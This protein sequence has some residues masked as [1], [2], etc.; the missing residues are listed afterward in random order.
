MAFT[1]NGLL[2]NAPSVVPDASFFTT[3]LGFTSNGLLGG[4]GEENGSGQVP[5]IQGTLEEREEDEM[6]V[7]EGFSS[8]G[9]LGGHSSSC[10]S[11]AFY[12]C[13]LKSIGVFSF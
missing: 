6:M 3:D 5:A 9:L 7:D 10:S 1:S 13:W 8:N 2:G 12:M 11:L 4:S